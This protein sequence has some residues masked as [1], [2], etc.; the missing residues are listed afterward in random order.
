MKL[1]PTDFFDLGLA[2]WNY[3]TAVGET[4]KATGS[5]IAKR[6]AIIDHAIRDPFH[7]DLGELGRMLP[8]K[9]S[10]FARSGQSLFVDLL[11]IQ[12]FVIAQTQDVMTV[13]LRGRLATMADVER[14]SA[15]A[16]SI[17]TIMAEASTR[18]LGPVHAT[19]TANERR[20]K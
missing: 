14:L 11:K 15:R 5:V 10:A 12:Q 3:W 4:A 16:L 18:A 1:A 20:L 13:T 7:S 6:S 19:V 8:E 17:V 9:I 2:G